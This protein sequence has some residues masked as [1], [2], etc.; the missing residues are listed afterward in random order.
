MVPPPPSHCDVR[1]VVVAPV[2]LIP[3]NVHWVPGEQTASLNVMVEKGGEGAK[4][5]ITCFPPPAKDLVK[6]G[7]ALPSPS[8]SSGAIFKG[9]TQ[10]FFFN[11]AA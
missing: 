7:E 2:N 11:P 10:T 4:M 3:R 5:E 1:F 8:A 9:K 6:P